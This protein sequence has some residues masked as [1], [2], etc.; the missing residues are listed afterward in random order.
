MKENMCMKPGVMVR[1]GF[2]L[3]VNAVLL[4]LL[5]ACGG[6]PSPATEDETAG[7]AP[8]DG[9]DAADAPAEEEVPAAAEVALF[10]G[11]EPPPSGDPMA[12]AMDTLRDQVAA[13]NA[14]ATVE[15]YVLPEGTTFDEVR[16]HYE[17]ELTGGGWTSLDGGEAAV[18]G[19]GVATWVNENASQSYTIQVFENPSQP[20]TSFLF[21]VQTDT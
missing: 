19:G 7:E 2:G 21:V 14:G 20:D 12:I 3:L 17:S 10:P 8:A 18:P 4:A 6:T 1:Y 11:A 16:S 15:A 13:Q 5:V 9:G